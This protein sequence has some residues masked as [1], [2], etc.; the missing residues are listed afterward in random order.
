MPQVEI[1]EGP[2]EVTVTIKEGMVTPRRQSCP[3]KVAG[4]TVVA[5]AKEVKEPI[6]AKLTYR[7]RYKTKDGDRQ[8][9]Y[10]Y[11]VS[12]FP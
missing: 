3:N 8:L 5:T 4:G 6:E 11:T 1:L 7:V 9:G 12:L 2:P 10:V